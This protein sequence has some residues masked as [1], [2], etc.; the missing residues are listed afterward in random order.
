M[1]EEY[2]KVK[3]TEPNRMYAGG[4]M[5]VIVT[6]IRG[7]DSGTLVGMTKQTK[8]GGSYFDRV[9]TRSEL[10]FHVEGLSE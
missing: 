9:V 2:V 8:L 3:G 4:F 6:C 10:K 7:F 1:C 5:I